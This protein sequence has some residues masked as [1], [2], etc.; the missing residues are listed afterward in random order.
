MCCINFK[1]GSFII[2]DI[3][4]EEGRIW[5][6]GRILRRRDEALEKHSQPGSPQIGVGRHL[7]TQPEIKAAALHQVLSQNILALAT[8][9][10]DKKLA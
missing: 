7:Q 6:Q 5:W 2:D 8:L 9:T 10:R 4:G 1:R 3:L